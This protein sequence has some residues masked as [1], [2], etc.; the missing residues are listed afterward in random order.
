MN[1]LS[2]VMRVPGIPPRALADGEGI[3]EPALGPEVVGAAGQ[4]HHRAGAEIALV[5]LA[6]VA[7]GFYD[8]GSPGIVESDVLA[9]AAL[10]PEQTPDHH[11]FIVAVFHLNL[12]NIR[13]RDSAL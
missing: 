5:H 9:V 12:F 4:L 6:I 1:L 13:L 7:H 8:S 2:P 11:V 10:Q 3:H